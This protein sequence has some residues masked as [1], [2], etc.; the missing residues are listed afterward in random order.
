MLRNMPDTRSAGSLYKILVIDD[1]EALRRM[2]GAQL[3]A[4]YEVVLAEGGKQALGLIEE[5]ISPDVII[6]DID[7]PGMDGY[8]TLKHLRGDPDMEDIPVIFLTSMDG[9]GDQVKGLESGAADYITKPFEMDVLLA[10]L[11]L[12]LEA[13]MERRRMRT[14]RKSG[15]VIELGEEK[16]KQLT[17][18]LDARGKRV[19][20][21]IA[22]GRKNREIASET[23]YSLDGVKKIAIRVYDKTSLSRDELRGCAVR[24]NE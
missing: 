5:G 24:R 12:R 18:A 8:E 4:Q 15:L 11:R 7:M 20:R 22:L 14:V 19:A 2:V 6:L 13:G 1:D 17:E 10:W 23:A 9:V 16:F 21:L 3:S